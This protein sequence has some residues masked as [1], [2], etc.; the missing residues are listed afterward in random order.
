MRAVVT[1]L[2]ILVFVAL[3][4]IFAV[5]LFRG[6]PSRVPSALIGKPV[7]QFDLPGFGMA[8]DGK[9]PLPGLK[10]ADL[11]KGKVTVVN[12][13]AS[14]CPPC[15]A[16]HP[17]LMSL[18]AQGTAALVGLNYKDTPANGAQFLRALGNPFSAVG[19][20]RNGRTGFEWGV[21]GVPET[22]VVD[23]KGRIAYKHVGP[24][25]EQ[26]L[27]TKIKPAIEA[28]KRAK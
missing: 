24:I 10:S 21:Y 19:V 6:D 26:S 5:S 8:V 1:A 16:E 28:A 22:F 23:G 15:R 3:A 20:D 25:T 7:P 18:A 27:K 17:L 12:V 9:G 13:W 4:V 2:P 14:W 11:A